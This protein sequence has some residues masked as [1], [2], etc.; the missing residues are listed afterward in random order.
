LNAQTI[1]TPEMSTLHCFP[2][3]VALIE[4]KDRMSDYLGWE[5]D[6]DK[7]DENLEVI[8]TLAAGLA[9]GYIRD[10]LLGEGP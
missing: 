5:L 3:V 10:H 1:S 8:W 6:S 2:A 9:D 7:L 4:L